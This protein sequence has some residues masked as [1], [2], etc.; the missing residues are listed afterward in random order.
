MQIILMKFLE[1]RI[2]PRA[3]LTKRKIKVKSNDAKECLFSVKGSKDDIPEEILFNPTIAAEMKK[4]VKKFEL[5]DDARLLVKKI[6][7]LRNLCLKAV[8]GRQRRRW[9]TPVGGR[10]ATPVGGRRGDAGGWGDGGRQ[11]AMAVG[12]ATATA[13][14]AD[15]YGIQ[16]QRIWWKQEKLQLAEGFLNEAYLLFSEAFKYFSSYGNMALFYAWA[17]PNG[18]CIAATCQGLYFCLGCLPG[19]AIILMF[20]ATFYKCCDDCTQGDIGKDGYC[21][22]DTCKKP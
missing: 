19:P 3:R 12:R 2:M 5:P 14:W 6:P 11:W 18:T 1:L 4:L 20:A 17:Q 13:N 15:N 22:F 21:L 16:K 9:A 10:T 7:V 8:G